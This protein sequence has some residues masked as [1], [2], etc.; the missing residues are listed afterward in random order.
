[1]GGKAGLRERNRA[2]GTTSA[3]S[4][5]S[6]TVTPSHTTIGRIKGRVIPDQPVKATGERS[7]TSPM[8]WGMSEAV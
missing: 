1:M 8:L 2:P 4:A 5:T 6:L 3:G 7:R